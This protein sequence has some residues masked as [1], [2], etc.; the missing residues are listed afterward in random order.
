MIMIW[1]L[2]VALGAEL[3]PAT[4]VGWGSHPQ[5]APKAYLDLGQGATV[6]PLRAA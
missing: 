2:W 5:R 1:V 6:P 4:A 3:Q